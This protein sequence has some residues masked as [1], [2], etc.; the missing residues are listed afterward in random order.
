MGGSFQ[1]GVVVSVLT[2]EGRRETRAQSRLQIQLSEPPQEGNHMATLEHLV[3]MA[4]NE[5]ISPGMCGEQHAQ[6]LQIGLRD[7]AGVS[8]HPVRF[9]RP[10]RF[11]PDERNDPVMLIEGLDEGKYLRAQAPTT[12]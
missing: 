8:H 9:R 11:H 4:F 10:R 2:T 12:R 5:A 7:Q 6:G 3:P 1:S